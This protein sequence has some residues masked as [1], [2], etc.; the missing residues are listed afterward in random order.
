MPTVG[1]AH[2][3]PY[4]VAHPLVSLV[5]AVAGKDVEAGFKPTRPALRDLYRFVQLMLIGKHSVV[6][7][8]EALKGEVAVQLHHGVPGGYRV[9]AVYLDF[10]VVLAVERQGCK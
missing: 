4:V 10:V 8:F 9:G 1:N 7:G 2:A 3:R 6:A 5:G